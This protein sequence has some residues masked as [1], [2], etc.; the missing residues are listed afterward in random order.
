MVKTLNSGLKGTGF[1][2]YPDRLCF[3]LEQ[4]NLLHLLH[5]TQVRMDTWPFSSFVLPKTKLLNRLTGGSGVLC[6][7]CLLLAVG[8]IQLLIVCKRLEHGYTGDNRYIK[9]NFTLLLKTSKNSLDNFTF[10]NSAPLTLTVFIVMS[11]GGV[12]MI[13]LH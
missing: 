10:I 7:I 1:E 3:F 2:S 9:D 5:S 12:C 13:T 8:V 11:L 6:V 4:E